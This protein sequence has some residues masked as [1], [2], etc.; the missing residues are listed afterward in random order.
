MLAVVF[1]KVATVCQPVPEPSKLTWKRVSEP[2]WVNLNISPKEEPLTSVVK[3]LKTPNLSPVVKSEII[4]PNSS[5][6]SNVK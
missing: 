4:S 1:D 3:A 2:D 6:F 5:V